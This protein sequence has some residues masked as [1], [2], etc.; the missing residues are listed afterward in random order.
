MLLNLINS[1]LLDQIPL[2][3]LGALAISGVLAWFFYLIFIAR[4]EIIGVILI[5]ISGLLKFY[6]IPLLLLIHFMMK[7]RLPID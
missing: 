2:A 7:N 1:S 4:L 5:G 3:G 6:S